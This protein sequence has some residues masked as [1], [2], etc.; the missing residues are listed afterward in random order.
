MTIKTYSKLNSKRVHSICALFIPIST[1]ETFITHNLGVYLLALRD[2]V[3]LL[4]CELFSFSCAS[5]LLYIG[6]IQLQY[7]IILINQ[8]PQSIAQWGIQQLEHHN[9]FDLAESAKI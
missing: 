1:T 9:L 7:H 6:R 4:L 8:L 2:C 5:A 3:H